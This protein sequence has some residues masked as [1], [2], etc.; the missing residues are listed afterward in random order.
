MSLSVGAI[1]SYGQ[2][3]SIKPLN[4]ALSNNARV[5]DAYQKSVQTQD[6]IEL[7]PPVRYPNAR[8]EASDPIAKANEATKTNQEFNAIAA[9]YGSSPI[10]Y[11][12]DST[13]AAY[14]QLGS[15]FDAIA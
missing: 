9:R 14:S 6:Q 15:S 7:V 5:S 1:S 8:T 12:A 2:L 4:Y 10:G 13:A 11:S 3:A